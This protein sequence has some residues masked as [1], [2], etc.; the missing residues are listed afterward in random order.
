MTFSDNTKHSF[1]SA[2]YLIIALVA[3]SIFCLFIEFT[4]PVLNALSQVT[5]A[6]LTLGIVFFVFKT[7]YMATLDGA[8][9]L[10]KPRLKKENDVGESDDKGLMSQNKS[11]IVSDYPDADNSDVY[12]FD[13]D[14]DERRNKN[15]P[16]N[17]SQFIYDCA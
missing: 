7:I 10:I 2:C 11:K 14:N 3:W 12:Y 16:S 6:F 5:S 4:I 1:K 17:S 8:I 13:D 15:H 9:S